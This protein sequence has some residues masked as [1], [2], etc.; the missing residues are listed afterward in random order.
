M[1]FSLEFNKPALCD[2]FLKSLQTKPFRGYL[3]FI[4]QKKSLKG[5]HLQTSM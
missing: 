5:N 2:S 3:C 4:V 1:C